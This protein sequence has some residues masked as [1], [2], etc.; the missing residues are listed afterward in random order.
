VGI[1]PT[2]PVEPSLRGVWDGRDE[3]LE[4]AVSWLV[5]QH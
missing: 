2:I 1:H 3:V 4:R 5:T